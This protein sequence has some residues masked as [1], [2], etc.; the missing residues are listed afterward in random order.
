MK[1]TLALLGLLLALAAPA[2]AQ[3]SYLLVIVGLG[4]D[5]ENSGLFHKWAVTLVDAARDRGKLPPENVIY[6]G[7]DPARDPKRISGR[8]TR[9]GIE[10][11][12]DRLATRARPGDIVFIVLIGHG[13][14]ATGE[15]KFNLPGPDLTMKDYARF[16]ARFAAQTV[17]FVDTASASG[18]FVAALSGPNR[19]IIT[20][21]RTD[22]ER[23]QTRFGEY[24]TEAFATDDAD[25]D[26]DGRVS[27]FEAFTW[28]RQ[29]TLSSYE[30]QRQIPTEHPVLDDDGDGKGTDEPGKG[31]SDGALA[32][33]VFL[34]PDAGARA[35][36]ATT[37]PVLK[38]LY[39]ERRAI[40]GRIASLKASKDRMIDAQYEHDM[41]QLLV[42]LAKKNRE[43]REK[44]KKA[45]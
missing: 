40:E 22:G 30:Q 12:V 39:E 34:A 11:A 44:E 31:G 32:R 7:E 19:V 4:G 8:S 28:A 33:T 37:D 29:R 15:P 21:T 24:F 14:S 26:K 17:V 1:R 23:N 38:A 9:E 18:G 41:E 3:D 13:A 45:S 42:E 6:L 16:V 10:A 25:L 5:A 36:A 20:A 27:L 43:I 35:A 2:A